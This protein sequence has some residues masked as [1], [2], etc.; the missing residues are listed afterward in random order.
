MKAKRKIIVPTPEEDMAINAGIDADPDTYE[1][2]DA[3][4]A[5]LKP[6]RGRPRGSG[7]KVQMTV[8]FD[9]DVIDAFKSTG[10]GWQTRMN[11]ALREWLGNQNAT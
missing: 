6:M 9:A 1:L 10:T 5:E 3:E 2:S 8:R 4:F 11:D 7:K